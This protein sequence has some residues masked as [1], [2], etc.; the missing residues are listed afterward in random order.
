MIEQIDFLDAMV[1]R[2]TLNGEPHRTNGPAIAGEFWYLFGK[3]H[4]YYGPRE[5]NGDWWIHDV[6]IKSGKNRWL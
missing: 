5:R 1:G 4:R 2:Y 6:Y 3:I